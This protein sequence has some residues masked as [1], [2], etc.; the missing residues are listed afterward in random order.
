MAALAPKR[1]HPH[2]EKTA[3]RP[4]LGVC[5]PVTG[6]TGL[7]MASGAATGCGKLVRTGPIESWRTTSR[8]AEFGGRGDTLCWTC[9]GAPSRTS[10]AGRVPDRADP[11]SLPQAAGTRSLRSDRALLGR[12]RRGRGGLL[13]PAFAVFSRPDLI[14]IAPSIKCGSRDGHSCLRPLTAASLYKTAHSDRVTLR[15]TEVWT[16]G[17]GLAGQARCSTRRAASLVSVSDFRQE[18][19]KRPRCEGMGG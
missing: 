5:W 13:K 14:K 1:D 10:R 19:A 8:S 2:P 12:H 16:L 17:N 4:A 15:P 11:A 7:L 18:P 6:G 9:G 3:E